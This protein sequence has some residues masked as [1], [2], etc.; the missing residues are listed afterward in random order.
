MKIEVWRDPYDAGFN[1][2]K[3]KEIDL[4]PGLTVLVGCNGT[5]K[6][7]LLMNIKDYCK[8]NIPIMKYDNLSDG[9][10][11]SYGEYINSGQFNKL[12]YLTQASEGECIKYHIGELSESIRYFIEYGNDNSRKN[13]LLNSLESISYKDKIEA[14]NK[15]FLECRERVFLFDAVDS[16]LSVDNIIELKDFFNLILE[17]SKKFDKDIY[18]IISANE[19]ELARNANCFDV[20]LGKYIRFKNYEDYRSFIIKTRERKEKRYIQQQ[21]YAEKKERKREE[22]IKSIEEKLKEYEN[23]D[24]F[25]L[26]RDK[27]FEINILK[28]RLRRLQGR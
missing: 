13:K 15:R 1:T 28:D 24:R 21:K 18:I 25:S 8:D 20:N 6:T 17:E 5:G 27:K 22:E 3:P 4:Q 9:G 23:I 7:T 12:A 19:Y 26:D 11:G 14:R 10:S 16:G 2:T